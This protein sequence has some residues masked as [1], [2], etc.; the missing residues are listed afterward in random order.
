MGRQHRWTSRSESSP[1]GRVVH[2]DT[3]FLVALHDR[4]W[5]SGFRRL[6]P[7]LYREGIECVQ[8]IRL[9]GCIG[10]DDVSD[11]AQRSLGFPEIFQ[12]F[13]LT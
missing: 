8:E 12:I 9:S 4:K 13:S 1:R 5:P 6:Q 10:A 7:L 11:F 3:E 2:A